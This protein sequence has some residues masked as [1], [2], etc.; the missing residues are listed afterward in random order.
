ML[1]VAP[2]DII[3][4]KTIVFLVIGCKEENHCWKSILLEGGVAL[5]KEGRRY[6]RGRR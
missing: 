1:K 4:A 6:G 3:T 5:G 2:K